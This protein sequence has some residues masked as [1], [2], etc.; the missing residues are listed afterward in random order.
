M[1]KG[2]VRASDKK[3]LH[4]SFQF[5]YFENKSTFYMQQ[6]DL[7]EELASIRNMM[8]RSSKFIS[9]SGLSGILAGVYALIG[10]AVVFNLLATDLGA[11]RHHEH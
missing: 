1:I 11:D 2:F 4:I 7:H 3:N 9:L 10:A 8:E 5:I 6:N